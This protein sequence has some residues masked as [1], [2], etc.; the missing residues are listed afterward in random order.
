MVIDTPDMEVAISKDFPA[1]MIIPP[2][3][4]EAIGYG[5]VISSAFGYNATED[6][7][8]VLEEVPYRASFE[9]ATWYLTGVDH[10]TDAEGE[11]VVVEMTASLNMNRRVASY[12]GDKDL[13]EQSP[14]IEIIEDWATA[15]VRFIVTTYNYSAHYADVSDSPAYDVNGSTEVKFDISIEINEDIY[16]QDLAMDIG[17]MMMENY[18][19]SPTSMPEQYVFHG[20]QDDG[21]SESDPYENETDGEVQIVHEFVPRSEF[22]QLFTFVEGDQED[23]FFGWGRQAEV[24][25]T[26]ED[27]ELVDIATL[28]RTDGESLRVYLSTP[29]DNATTT[30]THGPSLGLFGTGM[31]GG[32]DVPGDILPIGSSGESVLIGAAIGML[33][34]GMVGAY[35]IVRSSESE[36]PSDVVNLDKNR[37]Y[38]KKK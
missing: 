13:G 38:R 14:G 37:Y 34:V 31:N 3:Q 17:L 11:S 23:S 8:L 6:G 32:V 12:G 35:V 1:V 10:E 5:A 19:F 21:V 22:K 26:G 25:W 2:D 15:T 18:T 27:D 24:G 20:Y 28:Y 30:V 4:D 33:V 36:D 7:L 16:A 9:H 29:L